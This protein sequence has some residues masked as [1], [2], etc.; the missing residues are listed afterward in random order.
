MKIAVIAL[1][2][3]GLALTEQ[4]VQFDPNKQIDCYL[5]PLQE[6]L[7]TLSQKLFQEYAAIIYVMALGIVVRVTGPLLRDKRTDPAIIC[8]DEAGKFVI[9]VA[10]GHLGGANQLATELAR[11]LGSIPVI[12][13]ATDVQGKIAF[14]NLAKTMNLAIE[15]FERVKLLNSALVNQKTIGLYSQIPLEQAGYEPGCKPWTGIDVFCWEDF[16]PS[17]N[18]ANLVL[19]TNK[20][21]EWPEQ[22]TK[23]KQTILYLRPRNIIAGIGCRRGIS[24]E[25]ILGALEQA[26]KTAGISQLSFKKIA[27]IDL[28]SD[29][30]GLSNAAQ[31]R[32]VPIE[33]IKKNE[34][35]SYLEQHPELDQ[36][37][38][39]KTQIGVGSVCEPAALIAGRPAKLVLP[40]QK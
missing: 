25:K 5:G 34:I 7:G 17:T 10:S 9:S 2:K 8:I 27:S 24:S 14:D 29:E 4:I 38:Y 39:V 30:P 21:L 3:S 23:Q 28:K 35:A 20:I 15:P 31:Q 13:T 33:F 11:Y 18:Y 22:V 16:R 12:T 37:Q 36:S 1:T 19:I 6:P 32:A 40:K 26:F